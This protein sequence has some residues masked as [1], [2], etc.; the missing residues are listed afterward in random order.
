MCR[1]EML[2]TLFNSYFSQNGIEDVIQKI[3]LNFSQFAFCFYW[4]GK[5]GTKS[6]EFKEKYDEERIF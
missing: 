1:H 6:E 4:N 2:H 3:Y 5:N